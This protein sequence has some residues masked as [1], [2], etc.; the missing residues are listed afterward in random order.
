MNYKTAIKSAFK[1]S[2]RFLNTYTK[3][4]ERQ[5]AYKTAT[6]K[7]SID[8]KELWKPSQLSGVFH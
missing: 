1:F 8:S 3:Y 5:I 2:S 4:Q 7:A 6:D